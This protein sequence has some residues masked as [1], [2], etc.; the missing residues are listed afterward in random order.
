M[1]SLSLLTEID[2]AA[3]YVEARTALRP[4][5]GLV[6]GSGLGAFAE[7]LE[8]ATRIP[9]REIPHFPVST[10]IGH[11]GE[12]AVGRSGGVPVAVMAGRVHYYEG[13]T[14]QQVVFPIRV[15]GRLGVRTAILTN[16]AG[17]VNV[18]FAPGEL[19]IIED[20]INYLGMNP[21]MGPNEESLGLRF[22]DMSAAYDPD[23][24][25]IAERACAAAQVTARKG[26]YIAFTGPSYETPAEIRMARAMGADAV[27]MSTVPEVIAARHLGI[28]VLGLSCITNMAAG[29]LE[30]K[31]DHVEVL[32]VAER[33]RERLLDVLARIV[34]EAAATA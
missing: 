3:S 31:L 19:M 18:G 30:Q 33:V 5:I 11:K 14:P 26:V 10:A 7:T 34:A 12:L 32:D 21:L 28:R 22:F 25:R 1:Q 6:L 24:R 8:D 29:V 23:L 16:A 4:K 9:F 20:H 15:L 2:Q 17:S 27:G 13:Y